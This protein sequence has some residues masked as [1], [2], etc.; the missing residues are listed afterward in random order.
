MA[1]GGERSAVLCAEDGSRKPSLSWHEGLTAGRA[2]DEAARPERC[3]DKL[4]MGAGLVQ[5]FRT[6]P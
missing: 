2:G 3:F 1:W 4:S 5:S 6:T